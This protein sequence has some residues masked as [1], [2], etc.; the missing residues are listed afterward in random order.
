MLAFTLDGVARLVE[1]SLRDD[2]LARS[3][4]RAAPASPR[5]RAGLA[6]SLAMLAS[7]CAI[8]AF[9]M[10]V[11]EA[12]QDVALLDEVALPEEHLDDLAVDA[13]LDG[14]VGQRLDGARRRQ[15][16]GHVGFH[17]GGRRHRGRRRRAPCPRPSWRRPWISVAADGLLHGRR[18]A[19]KNRPAPAPTAAPAAYSPS[20]LAFMSTATRRPASPARHSHAGL[21]PLRAGCHLRR[22]E[23][24][25]R[26]ARAAL[27]APLVQHWP[28][29]RARAAAHPPPPPLGADAGREQASS[30]LEAVADLVGPEALQAHQ[31]LVQDFEILE[32]DLADRL[33]QSRAGADRASGSCRAPPCPLASG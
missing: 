12:K 27:D 15:D 4:L 7:A 20:R 19:K 33:P 5:R 10:P 23:W 32:R 1:R 14:D 28:R 30:S 2:L 11:V 21:R 18:S 6:W 22:R 17:H 3:A 8:C 13:R 9:T 29:Q 16:D 24:P 25:A 26:I 31:G